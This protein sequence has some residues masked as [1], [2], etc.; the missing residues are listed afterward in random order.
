M[1]APPAATSPVRR[2]A[3]V[4]AACVVA[5]LSCGREA[6]SPTAPGGIPGVRY[7]RGLSIQPVFPPILTQTGG[8][9][10]TVPF[11]H[12]RLLLLHS[13]GTVALDTIVS[14]TP[15]ADQVTLTVTVSL[16]PGAPATGEL[17]ALS[18]DYVNAAGVTVFHGGPVSVNAAPTV[19]GQPP[20]PPVQIPISY[21]G[22]GA[23]AV[24]VRISPKTLTVFAGD[25]FTFS[26]L[27]LDASGVVIPNTPVVFAV[28]DGPAT[29]STSGTGTAGATRG[30]A[31]I[32]AQ[33]IGGQTDIAALTVQLRAS[34]LGLVS[35]SGQTAV[36]GSVLGAPVV[37]RV[38]ATDGV[39][40]GGVSVAFA[41]GSGG[42]VGSATATTDVSGNASTTWT[43]GASAGLQNLTV[44]AGSLTGSP[45]AVSATATPK[46]ATRLVITS[47]PTTT[48]ANASF[49]VT[50][51]AQ[52]VDG[53][54]VTGFTGT[55]TLALTSGPAL[56]VLS[57]PTTA[58]TVAGVATF[59]G[60]ALKPVGTGYVLTAS[61][62]ALTPAVSGPIAVTVG[63][64]TMLVFTSGPSNITAGQ[65]MPAV[66]VT[67]EDANGNVATTFAGTVTIALGSNPA[68]G[69]LTG[70]TS[71]AAVAGVATFA[72]L[73]VNR[74]GSG[75]SL[76]AAASGLSGATSGGFT[77]TA[78]G[79]GPVTQLAFSVQ[80]A[81]AVAGVSL[82]PS[83]VVQARDAGNT[84]ITSFTGNVTLAIGANP[85]GS[86]LSGTLTVA[87]VAGVATFSNISLNKSGAG[88]TLS[89]SAA[90]LT[91]A[92]SAAFAINP[93][94]ASVLAFTVQPS[95][96][97]QAVS[98]APAIQVTAR[99]AFGNTATGFAGTVT[100]SFNTN[101]T[102]AALSGTLVLSAVAGVATFANISVNLAGAGY[103]FGAASPGLTPTASAPFTITLVV[104]SAQQ[105][106]N[107]AGG[108]WSNP[109]NWS[110]ARV[111]LTTD[112]IV[113]ALAGTYTV[114]LDTTFTTAKFIIVGGASGTQTLSLS[115][116]TLTLGGPMI[117]GAQGAF[118]ASSSVVAG[119]SPIANSGT[120]TLSNSTVNSTV[121][122]LGVLVAS[123]ASTLAG[124]LTTVPGSTLRVGQVDGC[125]GLA[126]LTVA[127]GF[128][129]NGAIELTVIIGITYSSQLTVASGTL[130]NSPGAT[131]TSLGGNAP[132]GTRTLA[133]QLN[134]QGTITAGT[135]APLTITAISAV[136]TNSGT[137]DLSAAGLTLQ[138]G[139]T[140]P[141]FTNTGTI[142]I[143]SGQ[144][145][146]VQNGAL[147][148]NAG[149]LGG[150]GT[151]S[152]NA[153]TAGFVAAIT[154]A[155]FSMTSSTATIS[156][157][158]STSTTATNLSGS[159]INGTGS[160]TNTGGQTLTLNN[161]T[162]NTALTNNG[163]LVASGTS[164]LGGTLTTGATS[165][166]RV[167]QVDGCCGLADLTVANGF[168]NNGAIELTVIVAIGY[169]TQL[170]VTSGTLVNASTGTITSLG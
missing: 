30:T 152:L 145:F 37:V 11:D 70:T 1:L 19:A 133:A 102:G 62:G 42:S 69:V 151:L 141:S 3:L 158:I 2:L 139:G 104:S 60:L 90:A 107:P 35:G 120:V 25:P 16:L 82:A 130:F 149:T 65:P 156:G 111:P 20:P 17:M 126:N 26:A 50:V 46:P 106:I 72:G 48:P 27:A 148:H 142:T 76:A 4:G 147:N 29:V 144:T 68:A 134:N 112:S 169:S 138:Q 34:A 86:T 39:G 162:I 118:F 81:S 57:G 45:L 61:S 9:A 98:I 124:T 33:L 116:R 41:A 51:A 129:N 52:D 74:A 96:A 84:L 127:N 101:P 114:T 64:A 131:I 67:A 32:V 28:S 165:T 136:S 53:H 95:T 15:G 170:T 13:D 8:A 123:G 140:T 115:G 59:G 137:I 157:A 94:A 97:V 105:W 36:V 5:V 125:C 66:T 100:L 24:S 47:A 119:A 79:P 167:G 77:V 99:D 168:T 40:V 78:A 108:A 146:F 18:M 38:T 22:P 23:A 49:S 56:G 31:H 161:S 89:A 75:Y 85:G 128:T 109:A 150:L 163:I 166:L 71:A 58:T 113:I 43:L 88:Y 160:I 92:T 135:G 121:T 153:V 54:V 154:P 159:T 103:V 132:G 55:V 7:A 21:T 93:A 12:V 110:Q 44:S 155:V 83:I 73:S 117:V 164:G 91:S 87:A 14:F 10:S 6:G 80:P 143:G 63:P 122:N